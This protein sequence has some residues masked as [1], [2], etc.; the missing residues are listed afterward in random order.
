MFRPNSQAT[1]ACLAAS[2]ILLAS[3]GSDV[4]LVDA[5]LAGHILGESTSGAVGLYV[6]PLATP[7]SGPQLIFDTATY[8]ELISARSMSADY[9]PTMG[10]GLT[11]YLDPTLDPAPSL[12]RAYLMM[13]DLDNDCI[14]EL[15]ESFSYAV[16]DLVYPDDAF[17]L[18]D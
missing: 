9:V 11:I 3:C 14:A 17:F 5:P 4:E 8:P 15:G 18:F 13:W 2:A 10:R 12:E 6:I 7:S 1:T 16:F